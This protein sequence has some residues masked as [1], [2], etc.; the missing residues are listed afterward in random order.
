M[1]KHIPQL[2]TFSESLRFL[3]KGSPVELTHYLGHGKFRGVANGKAIRVAWEHLEPE[4]DVSREVTTS[5]D[6]DD[7][8]TCETHDADGE[9]MLVNLDQ[10]LGN[11]N[12]H[13]TDE[14]GEEVYVSWNELTPSGEIYDLDEFFAEQERKHKKR[15]KDE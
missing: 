8:I 1:E 10:Y 4:K 13:G 7:P 2:V 5:I 9:W 3:I 14:D 6:M 11:G 15:K 12:W